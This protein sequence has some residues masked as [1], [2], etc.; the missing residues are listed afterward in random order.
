M[1]E[2]PSAMALSM[3]AVALVGSGCAEQGTTGP[4]DG[5]GPTITTQLLRLPGSAAAMSSVAG[6]SLSGQAVAAPSPYAWSSAVAISAFRSPIR[7]ISLEGSGQT[8]EIYDCEA[9][10]N[11]GCLVD[12]AGPALQNLLSATPV[13]IPA[14]TFD[15]VRIYTCKEEGTYQAEL[16]GSVTL[17][18]TA[19]VTRSAGV[20]DTAGAAEPVAIEYAGCARLYVLPTPL[21]VEDTAGAPIAFKLYFDIRDLAWASLGGDETAGGW[22]PGGCAGPRPEGGA[23]QPYLCTGY[24]DVA[25]VVDSVP[26]VIERYRLNDGATL[27]LI[28]QASGAFIGGFS[29]RYFETGLNANPGFNADTPVETWTDN[30]DGTYAIATFG[31]TGPGGGPVGHYLSIA[32]FQRQDHT[33]NATDF[34]GNVFPYTAVR[35]D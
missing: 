24:P 35:I 9:D 21:V 31:G 4:A 19:Y 29:R 5:A 15:A 27:G 32:A 28:F 17:D 16:T 30:G 14:G 8:V 10:S 3:L 1:I 13:Q 11:D 23:N 25:G 6:A 26:P 12:L 18:G 22:I 33:G 34:Q 20:L 7:G 2:K